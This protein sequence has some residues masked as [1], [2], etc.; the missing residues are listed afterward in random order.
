MHGTNHE[1]IAVRR[2]FLLLSAAVVALLPGCL[3]LYHKTEVMRGDEARRPIQF[4]NPQVADKFQQEVKKQDGHVGGSY[5][6]VPFLT[7][8]SRTQQLSENALWNECILKCDTNQDGMI[9]EAEVNV[10]ARP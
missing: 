7:V 2:S 4:E 10:F 8:F 6:G 5:L 3:T 1:G 9:S